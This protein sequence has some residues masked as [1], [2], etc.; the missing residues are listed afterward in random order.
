VSGIEIS[1]DG[2]SIVIEG[3]MPR[4][5]EY[6]ISKW[7]NENGFKNHSLVD[8]WPETQ[9][10]SYIFEEEAEAILCYLRFKQ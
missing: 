1:R 7:A 4:R 2:R 10:L 6:P 9:K 3:V 5:L 8:G